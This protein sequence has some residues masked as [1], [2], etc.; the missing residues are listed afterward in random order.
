MS[1]EKD[2]KMKPMII[3]PPDV[4]DESNVK[5]LRENG[6][7]VVVASDPAKVKFVDP[8]PAASSRTQMEDAA[9]R[10]SRRLLAGHLFENNRRDFANLYV[11]CLIKGTPLDVNYVEP[12]VRDKS[13]FDTAKQDELRRLAREE[14][15]AERAA[16]KTKAA[17]EQKK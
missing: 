4:M 2:F 12:E 7:C 17:T 15:K 6:I 11:D 3:L 5:L 16:A 13:I 14:A 1:Q 9:I 10:L 8:I